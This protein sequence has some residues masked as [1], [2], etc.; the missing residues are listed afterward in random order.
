MKAEYDIFL[1]YAREDLAWCEQLAARL[2]QAGVRVWFDR[3]YVR[4]GD[5]LLVRLNE[6]L[7]SSVRMVAV[8]SP[9]YF[10]DSKVWTLVESFGRQH[11]DPLSGKRPLIP[12]LLEDCRI[13]PTLENIVSIDFRQRRDFERSFTDLLESLD[14]PDADL[15]LSQSTGFRRQNLEQPLIENPY[16]RYSGGSLVMDSKMFYGRSELLTRLQSELSSG[17]AGRCFVLYGQ[18]RTGKSSVLVQLEQRLPPPCLPVVTTLGLLDPEASTGV[19]VLVTLLLHAL[20][21]A[22]EER[23]AIGEGRWTENLESKRNPIDRLREALWAAEE[24]LLNKGWKEPR[25]VFLI[26]E[27]SLLFEYIKEGIIPREF[28]RQWKALLELRA[29]NAVLVGQD[30]MPSF[31]AGFPNEFGVTAT[32]RITYLA[33]AEARR[34]ADEP[35]RLGFETRYRG[36]ALGHLLQ[37]TAGSPFYTH[38]FC[39]RLVEYLNIN[40][41]LLITETDIEAV[42]ASMVSGRDVLSAAAFD[43][44]ITAAGESVAPFPRDTYLLALT[45]IAKGSDADRGVSMSVLD[46]CSDPAAL[47]ADLIGRDVVTRDS[48]L[49]LHIRVGLFAQWLRQNL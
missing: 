46:M 48:E 37:L 13:P 3:W 43:P 44:L 25:I 12:L 42:A 16:R 6:A 23:M 33:D 15:D 7:Q 38:M 20:R 49:R 39:S 5:H 27:F 35:I 31:I 11:S 14:A 40:R 2:R 47:V 34:L 4:P 8:W 28:M 10:R 45:A 29:F 32:E 9:N 19:E 26:D 18:K 21:R 1:S 30:S 24:L 22:L 36:E 17:S 41:R